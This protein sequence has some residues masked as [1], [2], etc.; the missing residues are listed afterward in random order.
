MM[1]SQTE[2]DFP[3]KSLPRTHLL[4]RRAI[5]QPNRLVISPEAFDEPQNAVSGGGGHHEGILEAVVAL[6]ATVVFG[7][8]WAAVELERVEFHGNGYAASSPAPG[9]TATS[10]ATATPSARALWNLAAADP[11]PGSRARSKGPEISP[12]AADRPPRQAQERDDRWTRI[13]PTLSKTTRPERKAIENGS[14]AIGFEPVESNS[15]R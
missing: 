1:S 4:K 15:N 14:S 7:L 10:T 5:P 2:L 6:L 9:S 12:F 3:A 11:G 8:G 13:D